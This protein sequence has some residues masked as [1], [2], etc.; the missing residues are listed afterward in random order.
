MQWMVL[1]CHLAAYPQ[2]PISIYAPPLAHNKQMA[3]KGK[4]QD[5]L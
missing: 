5:R 1:T 2:Q 3:Q 4:Q